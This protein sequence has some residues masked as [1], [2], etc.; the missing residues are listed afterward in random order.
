MLIV[1]KFVSGRAMAQ[2]VSRRPLTAE[3][4]VHARASSCG[5]CSGQSGTGTGFKIDFR[6]QCHST[7]A[8]H[9]HIMSGMNQWSQFRV[10]V[11][12]YRHEQREKCNQLK[13]IVLNLAQCINTWQHQSISSAHVRC[14]LVRLFFPFFLFFFILSIF[15]TFTC[16]Y[17]CTPLLYFHYT[18]NQQLALCRS[19][20]KAQPTLR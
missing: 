19:V 15:H 10:I 1:L 14:V 16:K 17:D 11:L 2:A 5:I 8:A 7:L 4:R 3:A 12:P 9:T 18:V 13:C 20:I 6:W